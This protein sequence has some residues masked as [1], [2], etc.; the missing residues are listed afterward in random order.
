MSKN[1]LTALLAAGFGF[2][3]NAAVAQ[4]VRSD[5]EKAKTEEQIMQQKEQG[6]AQP[7]H[8]QRNR[9]TTGDGRTTQ[10]APGTDDNASAAQDQQAPQTQGGQKIPGQSAPSVGH[11]QEGQTTGQGHGVKKDNQ[12]SGQSDGSSGTGM[13]DQDNTSGQ[14][15]GGNDQTGQSK[16]R[17][18]QQ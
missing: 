9:P 6:V 12:Q 3:L 7:A 15:G 13:R 5:S 11:R 18:T 1:L 2:G 8:G 4:D 14:A 16:K 10:S 17:R